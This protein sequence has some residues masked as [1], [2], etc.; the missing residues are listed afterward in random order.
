MNEAIPEPYLIEGKLP[1]RYPRGWFCIGTGYEFTSIP[2][3]LDYFGTSLV[4]YRGADSGEVH[5][6]DAYCPHMGANLAGGQVLGDSVICPFHA[7]SWGADGFCND[8]PYAD[9]IP[10]KARIRSWPV[11]EENELVYVWNDPDGGPPI[12]AQRIPREAEIY[13]ENWTPWVIRRVAVQSNCRELIDNMADKAHFV[14]VHGAEQITFFQNISEGHTYTQL[15]KGVS[16]GGVMDSKATYY[17]PGYMFHTMRSD[18]PTG[19][20]MRFL[21]LVM[22][23][24]TAMDSFEFLAGF[25]Y[26]VPPGMEGNPVAQID[27]VNQTIDDNVQGVFADLAIWQD[28]V[29][30]D[31]PL[32]CDG[33]GPVT[34]LRHW[35]NQF[36]VPV[37][38]VPTSLGQRKL[39]DKS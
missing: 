11:M 6:L 23:V 2:R 4:A 38:E 36:L 1:E 15:M 7:W 27:F 28:K 30:I 14:P 5:V 33:D 8:I 39:Y 37:D 10:K 13:D 17:G 31:N 12:E 3:K 21:S 35:Y 16:M 29:T 19:E 22:N 24:P 20:T 32:L 18:M 34:R 26:P 9:K 25:K